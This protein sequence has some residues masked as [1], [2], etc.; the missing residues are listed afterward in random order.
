M[1]AWFL[2]AV[3]AQAAPVAS[4][5]PSPSA[6]ASDG[7]VPRRLP[8]RLPPG[9]A[10]SAS[11]NDAVIVDSGS[12]NTIGYT[13]VIHPD[14]SAQVTLDGAL[15]RDATLPAADAESLFAKLAAAAPLDALAHGHCMKSASFGTS[16]RVAYAGKVSPDLTCAGDEQARELAGAVGAI[17]AD[18]GIPRGALRHPN[19]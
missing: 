19:F 18:L 17:V 4:P 15:P 16:R 9:P 1:F 2:A 3:P 10:A 8:W 5:E 13:I 6:G 11:P 14:Y 12:T 7:N